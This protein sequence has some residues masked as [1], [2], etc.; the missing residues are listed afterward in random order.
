MHFIR[1]NQSNIEAWNPINAFI[2]SQLSNN[3]SMLTQIKEF[4]EKKNNLISIIIYQTINI[5]SNEILNVKPNNTHV[6]PD[7][8]T[9]NLF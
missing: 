9:P 5:Q 2:Q 1:E 8:S 3:F 6:W 4:E 7:L